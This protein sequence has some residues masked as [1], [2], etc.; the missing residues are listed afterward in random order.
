MLCER[1][2]V[3]SVL[4]VIM[5]TFYSALCRNTHTHISPS[6]IQL[7][8]LSVSQRIRQAG[9][10]SVSQLVTHSVSQLVSFYWR[11][12]CT[13]HQTLY[14]AFQTPQGSFERLTHTHTR[15]LIL[16]S[17]TVV[18]SLHLPFSKLVTHSLSLS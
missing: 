14:F 18:L 2:H 12:V 4:L 15:L 6:P 8:S 11:F 5:S 7:V 1:V 16:E 10:G 9:S 3:L 17:G 13:V